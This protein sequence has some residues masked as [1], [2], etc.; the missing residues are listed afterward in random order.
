MKK[1]SNSVKKL[2]KE[3]K[4]GKHRGNN[5]DLSEKLELRN[6]SSDTSMEERIKDLRKNDTRL[7]T[8]ETWY[9]LIVE[10][11][12]DGI[13]QVD[14]SGYFI[15]VN[16]AFTEFFGYKREDLLGT[17]FS[18]LLSNETS[19]PRVKKMVDAVFHGKNIRDEV[20]MKHKDGHDVVVIFSAV[21]LKDHDAIVGLTGFL[22][23][24]TERKKNEEVLRKSEENFRNVI[25]YAP[26]AI[27]E[28]DF[29][30]TN[31]RSV[32]DVVCQISGYTRDELLSMNPLGLLDEESKKRF[33][34]NIKK[35][36]AGEKIDESLELKIKIK[37]GGDLTVLV[38]VGAF[39]FKDGKPESVL[40]IAHNITERKKMEVTLEKYRREIEQQNIQLKKVDQIKTNFLNVTSHELRTPMSSIK[41]YTQM[42]SKQILGQINDEQMKALDIILR[43]TNRLDVLIQDVLDI[44]RLESGTMKFIVER[45][46]VKNMILETIEIMRP[47]A[48]CKKMN[49]ITE[50]EENLPELNVDNERIKQVLINIISNAIKFSTNGTAINILTKRKDDNIVF[51]IQ[52]FGRGIPRNEL[53]KVFNIFYQVDSGEDRKYGGVGLG[54][55]ISRGIVLA[56]G[57]KIWVKSKMNEGSTFSFTLP[58]KPV[59]N[60]ETRFKELNIF[61]LEKIETV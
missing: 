27:Y 2:K 61:G 11:C 15:F 46:D 7:K 5:Q 31:F 48:T 59:Q 58:I 20:T 52:D 37:D 23:D 19:L 35:K 42:I 10:S 28:I 38:S 32:N 57:G 45:T 40:V 51:E 17:H 3:E 30:G 16:N 47:C 44:S 36:L 1:E 12:N 53:K 4:Q 26:V 54:L 13:Y 9:K 29:Y 33:Q 24:I 18:V 22:R 21:P 25:K 8:S 55:P 43:N 34:E 14:K 39:T 56:H 49:F 60:I 41:G 6:T 50:F